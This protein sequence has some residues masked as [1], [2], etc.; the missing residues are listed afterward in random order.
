MMD[1][2]IIS[3]TKCAMQVQR[4]KKYYYVVFK[5]ALLIVVN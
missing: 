2:L 4:E 3:Q 5:N 1:V